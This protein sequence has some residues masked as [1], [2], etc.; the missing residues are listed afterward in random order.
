MGCPHG[1]V[2]HGQNIYTVNSR[3]VSSKCHR[4]GFHRVNILTVRIL[5]T[6]P[7]GAFGEDGWGWLSIKKGESSV[8]PRRGS[9][10]QP[11]LWSHALLPLDYGGTCSYKA[12]FNN[13]NPKANGFGDFSERSLILS[14][15]GSQ[16]FTSAQKTKMTPHFICS[17]F[18][19]VF[20]YFA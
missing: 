19:V 10:L 16:F 18:Y 9:N 12:V 11:Q 15:F 1:G 13:S 4:A 6:W 17:F 3:T 14:D 7:C 8:T 2:P 5:P 20:V